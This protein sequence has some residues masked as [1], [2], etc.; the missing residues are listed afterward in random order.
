MRRMPGISRSGAC[1]LSGTWTK[2]SRRSLELDPEPFPPAW[3]AAHE[4]V[5]AGLAIRRLRT[6]DARAAIAR[7][8][9]AAHHA[10][11]PALTAEVE[12]ASL[13]LNTPAARLIARGEERLLL[14]EEVE[15]L[16]AS[17]SLVVDACR[18]VVRSARTVIFTHRTSGI[19][20]AR[21]RTGR[22]MARR[23]AKRSAPRQGIW[24]EAGGRIASRAFASRD[25][26]SAQA[27]S[28]VGRHHR[29]EAGDSPSSLT[30]LARWRCWR[31]LWMRSMLPCLPSSPTVS[32]GRVQPWRSPLERASAPCS[33]RSTRLPRQ[34]RC[35][36]LVTRALAVG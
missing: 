20:R 33:G 5:V 9:R 24:S 14:L 17:K 16:L 30:A 32:H 26:A 15:A 8:E 7:A 18:H 28:T 19:V 2:P 35:S 29:D 21:T 6:Q 1:S 23:R 13:L 4:L 22:S 12:S 10:R 25:R 36:R 11:I 3:R 34:G 31:G 27:A